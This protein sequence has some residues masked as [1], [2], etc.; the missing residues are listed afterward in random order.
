MTQQEFEGCCLGNGADWK[1][2]VSKLMH[3]MFTKDELQSCSVT[4]FGTS[5]PAL[6]GDRKSALI[7]KQLF[8]QITYF[9]N[10]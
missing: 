7:S 10:E 8:N 4:G 6:P 5:K 2:T 1:K 3:I 9:P